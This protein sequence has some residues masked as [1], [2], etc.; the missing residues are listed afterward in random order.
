MKTPNYYNFA[1]YISELHGEPC[2]HVGAAIEHG[3]GWVMFYEV[4]EVPRVIFV[5]CA[6]VGGVV[7]HHWD[8]VAWNDG[9]MP[10]WALLPHAKHAKK[11]RMIKAELA[12]AASKDQ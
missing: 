7:K 12:K 6:G 10:D 2:V 5:N 11:K 8:M 4:H 3:C 1:K 9:V